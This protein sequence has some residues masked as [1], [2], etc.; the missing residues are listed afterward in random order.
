MMKRSN[1][2]WLVDTGGHVCQARV[3]LGS[4]TG[5]RRL[6]DQFT[7]VEDISVWVTALPGAWISMVCL[8]GVSLGMQPPSWLVASAAAA[9]AALLMVC[10]LLAWRGSRASRDCPTFCFVANAQLALAAADLAAVAATLKYPIGPRARWRYFK[11]LEAV[12]TLAAQ[13][14]PDPQQLNRIC[15]DAADQR[16]QRTTKTDPPTPAD[17]ESPM[18]EAIDL[19]ER[20]LGNE[21]QARRPTKRAA[22]ARWHRR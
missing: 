20:L 2:V 16:R 21:E 5:F 18:N 4:L 11:A 14:S 13:E 6:R 17:F 9:C 1:S 15:E 22:L 12:K 8:V 3:R 19:T 7:G 10:A